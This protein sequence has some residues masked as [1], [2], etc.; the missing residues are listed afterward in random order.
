MGVITLKAQIELIDH[1]LKKKH[2]ERDLRRLKGELIKEM[3]EYKMKAIKITQP[4]K[5]LKEIK[6]TLKR[7]EKEDQERQTKLKL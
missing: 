6:E 3:K 4:R 7:I 2:S 1:L 5:S